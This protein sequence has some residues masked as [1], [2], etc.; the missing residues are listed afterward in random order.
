[1]AQAFLRV[2]H[3]ALVSM[4]HYLVRLTTMAQRASLSNLAPQ[5]VFVEEETTSLYVNTSWEF[6]FGD[7]ILDVNAGLRYEETE[8]ESPGQRRVVD[9]IVWNGGSEW[10]TEFANG[11]AFTVENFSGDYDVLLPM[12]DLR[13]DVTDDVVTRLSWGKSISRAAPGQLLVVRA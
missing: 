11:G 1:M 12:F 13:M 9:R 6:E 8:V 4:K 5:P 2:I 3:I 10:R 7:Y